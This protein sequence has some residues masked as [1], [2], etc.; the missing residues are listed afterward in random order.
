MS[1]VSAKEIDS[2]LIP[3]DL[4]QEKLSTPY[5]KKTASIIIIII[6]SLVELFDENSKY[7]AGL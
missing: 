5:R 7:A 2:L 4:Q 3:C 1:A 6:L